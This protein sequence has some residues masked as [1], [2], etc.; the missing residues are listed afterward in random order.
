MMWKVQAWPLWSY[1]SLAEGIEATGL[2]V[3]V[4]GWWLAE[5]LHSIT[6]H[7]NHGQPDLYQKWRHMDLCYWIGAFTLMLQ[8][9]LMWKDCKNCKMYTS[10]AINMCLVWVWRKVAQNMRH[11][12][13]V[14]R[15][16][17]SM[18][19]GQHYYVTW[20]HQT[21]KIWGKTIA[22]LA[23]KKL[24]ATGCSVMSCIPVQP[25]SYIPTQFIQLITIHPAGTQIIVVVLECWESYK[26][27]FCPTKNIWTL[28]F[29]DLVK[30]LKG[31]KSELMQGMLQTVKRELPVQEMH[32]TA[33]ISWPRWELWKHQ[34]KEKLTAK[35]H[36]HTWLMGAFITVRS[37]HTVLF[38]SNCYVWSGS[39]LF[40]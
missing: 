25:A 22:R 7:T 18:D 33:T 19:I 36:Q 5:G 23:C 39:L 12:T 26:G 20:P 8:C 3:P 15:P 24:K 21:W 34:F 31:L 13:T 27:N 30:L 32:E 1:M 4:V 35:H 29:C 38:F 16:E 17:T 10:T 14:W 2:A 6:L 40:S 37:D 28:K 9:S 11:P